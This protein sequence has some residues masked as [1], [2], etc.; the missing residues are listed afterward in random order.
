MQA[1]PPWVQELAAPRSS[2]GGSAAAPS[3][4]AGDGSSA[5]PG[6]PD[7]SYAQGLNRAQREAVLANL[8]QPLQVIAG[9]GSGKTSVLTRRIQHMVASGV[10]PS[11]VLA[12]TFTK[13]AADEMAQRLQSGL[14]QS[15]GAVS[16]STFHALSL[17][18]CRAYA[19]KA[20][21]HA[22]AQQLRTC[23]SRSPSPAHR[24]LVAQA[25]IT[26]LC[27]RHAGR[28]KDFA[29]WTGRQQMKAVRRALEE[30]R[31]ARASRDAVVDD[32]HAGPEAAEGL[33]SK[34]GS[35]AAAAE[36]PR[37]ES[38]PSRVLSSVMRAKAQGLAPEQV[39]D[40]FVS[41]VFS[42]RVEAL[43][44]TLMLT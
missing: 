21:E 41:E 19:D 7:P 15:A 27:C 37:G 20:G 33:A 23:A 42:R 40:P 13:A 35:A 3:S 39:T 14:G 38:D 36:A 16:V 44:L 30:V 22:P 1:T 11:N 6:A 26:T 4:T 10:S 34:K 29:V 43:T 24:S 8:Y 5:A 31:V 12:V 25:E 28:Q 2:G 32:P 18:L 9:A 17:A